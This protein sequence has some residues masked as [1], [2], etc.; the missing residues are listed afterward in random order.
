MT[1]ETG[2]TYSVI[3]LILAIMAVLYQLLCII[4]LKYQA[5]YLEMKMFVFDS[6][7]QFD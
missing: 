4:N 1:D 5:I 7:I 3:A 2:F 6:G